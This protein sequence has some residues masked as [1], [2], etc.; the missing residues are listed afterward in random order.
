M[1]FC[2]CPQRTRLEP[3]EPAPCVV[4]PGGQEHSESYRTTHG[5]LFFDDR[6]NRYVTWP[7]AVEA[8]RQG[9]YAGAANPGLTLFTWLNLVRLIEALHDPFVPPADPLSEATA[10][11]L[12][13]WAGDALPEEE[14]RRLLAFARGGGTE[15]L[16]SL[17][18]WMARRG[19]DQAS[20]SR[21]TLPGV[22]R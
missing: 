16:A 13:G 4:H 21:S 10:T 12:I 2:T 1:G 5:L 20:L 7:D 8:M 17:F 6:R 18:R 14:R 11:A 3:V 22:P 19:A 9:R 15:S